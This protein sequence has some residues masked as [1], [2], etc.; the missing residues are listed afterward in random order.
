MTQGQKIANTPLGSF[1][2]LCNFIGYFA[3]QLVQLDIGGDGIS[4]PVTASNPLPV[5][6]SGGSVGGQLVTLTWSRVTLNSGSEA[7]IIAANTSRKYGSYL[8]NNSDVTQTPAVLWGAYRTTS[9][10]AIDSQGWRLD[11]GN[12]FPFPTQQE[13][14]GIQ[15]SGQPLILD[16]FE[17]T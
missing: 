13:L 14:R 17:A 4:S 6:V 12:I 3:R 10:I 15:S 7:R 16:I 1:T 9:E 8:M 2:A 5:T 11:P